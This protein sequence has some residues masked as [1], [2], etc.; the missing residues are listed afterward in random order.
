MELLG[1]NRKERLLDCLKRASDRVE[2]VSPYLSSYSEYLL[3][4]TQAKTTLITAFSVR[5]CIEGSNDV[6]VVKR[7]LSNGVLTLSNLRLH[8]KIFLFDGKEAIWGSANLTH[9]GFNSNIE[10]C[11]YSASPLIVQPLLHFANTIHQDADTRN[12]SENDITKI[13]DIVV[14]IPPISTANDTEH[15]ATEILSTLN[16]WQKTVFQII[17][18]ITSPTVTRF[19]RDDLKQ[20]QIELRQQYPNSQTPMQ[21]V[22]R[23][24][25]ELRNKGLISFYGEGVYERVF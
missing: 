7:L 18:K 16:N 2:I 5:N 8:A 21:T 25:Q 14:K 23:V 9:R 20:Y 4:H 6:A 11:H 15:F 12:I 1:E 19:T 10:V 24:L 3:G 17:M 22:S 13:Q